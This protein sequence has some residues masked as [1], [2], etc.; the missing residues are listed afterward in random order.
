MRSDTFIHDFEYHI[1]KILKDG[2]ILDE[3]R[4]YY[5]NSKSTPNSKDTVDTTKKS[6][7]LHKDEWSICSTLVHCSRLKY[8]DL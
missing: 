2:S 7:V 4:A 1:K 6:N 3:F 5:Q 8:R